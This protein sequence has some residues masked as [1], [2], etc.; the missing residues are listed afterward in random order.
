MGMPPKWL[1]KIAKGVKKASK[2]AGLRVKGTGKA[3]TKQA[4]KQS[5]VT[6]YKDFVARS[7][8]GDNLEGHVSYQWFPG[9]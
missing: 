8:V 7:V 2:A 1:K 6:I 3:T 9:G 5:E 4:T